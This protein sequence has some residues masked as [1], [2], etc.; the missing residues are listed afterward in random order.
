MAMGT[1]AKIAIGCGCVVLAGTV[2]VMAV[3]GAGAFWA[4]G[5]IEEASS[6]IEAM[7]AQSEEADRFAQKANAN[8]Y[9]PS[10]DGVIVEPRLLKFLDVRRQ[11]FAV[12]ERYRPELEEIQKKSEKAG[13]KLSPG[14]LWSAGGSL[15]KMAGDIR[16][17]QMKALA[18]IG[19][20][21]DEYRDIQMAVYRSAWAS[22]AEASGKLPAE[23]V[24]PARARRP[25]ASSRR[26]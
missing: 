6:S 2:A 15:V 10:A 26:P 3:V 9:T 14:E 20:S 19:M 18:E 4:K 22:E 5:K 11:V 25:L 21:E 8:P 13:D 24:S 1:G 23:A 7:T 12:Y 17:A 16:L